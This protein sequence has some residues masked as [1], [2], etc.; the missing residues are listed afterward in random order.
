MNLTRT[1]ASN[2]GLLA[3]VTKKVLAVAAFWLLNIST[4]K[5]QP[6]PCPP[7]L[8]FETGTFFLWTIYEGTYNGWPNTN[9]G[10]VPVIPNPTR[11]QITSGAGLDPYGSFPEVAPG[12]GTYSLKLGND[13]VGAQTDRARYYIHVP[14]NANN[15]SFVYKYAVVFEDPGHSVAQQPRFMIRAYDSA[16]GIE[17]P[18]SDQLFIAGGNIPGF[19]TSPI[20]N[21]VRFKPWSSGS[22]NL[23]G[24][25]GKT[26]IVDFE[27]YDC[28]PTGH[29]GYGY[30][31]MISCGTYNAVVA[32]CNLTA[33]GITLAGPPG[34]MTYQWYTSNW[35]PVAGGS[36][37]IVPNVAAPNPASYFYLVLIPYSGPLC[38]DTLQ[39]NLVADITLQVTSDTLCYK[40]GTPVQITTNIG[41]G[42]PPLNIQWTG[43]D[44]S[45]YDCVN[46][47]STTTGNPFY[48]VTVTDSNGCFRKDTIEF[49]ESNFTM[50]AGDSF[51][52]CIGTPVQLN[53]WVSPGTGNYTYTW[54][55]NTGL[56]N[57]N[58][59]TPTFTPST[60]TLGDPVTYILTI[61]SGYCRK[62]DSITI[63]TLP[64][65]FTLLDTAVC[66]GAVF[67]IG[68]TG[69]P[70]FTYKWT[71]TIGLLDSTV[72]NPF[73][74][75]DTTR[76]Y[77]VTASYPTC[78]TIVKSVTV[79]VQP[80]PIVSLG[81]DTTKC[82]WDI[83][84]INVN[85]T[86]NWYTNYTYAWAAHP[87]LSSINSPNVLFTGQQSAGL[88]V[89]VTTPA[90]CS[91][92]DSLNITVYPGDFAKVTPLDTAVCPNS[93]VPLHIT[94][95]VA[96]DWTP[97]M[98]L[99]DSTIADPVSYPV[100][101][102]DYVTVVVDQYGC[103]DTVYSSIKVNSEALVFMTDT[104]EIYPDEQA[105]LDPRGN[106]LYYQWWPPV[107]LSA[108]AGITPTK[109]AN[110][111]AS[112]EVNTRYYVQ[113]TTEAG[114]SIIDSINVIVKNET[115]LDAPNAF[116]PGSA[117]NDI[118]KIVK[119]GSA[120]LKSFRVF[121][122][123]GAKVFE[124][125]NI[126][127]GWDGRLNGQPQPMGVYV[128]MIEAVTKSGK[129]FVK[130]GNVTLIR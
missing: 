54:T 58:A 30:V 105:Q 84:P 57:A 19:S 120:T 14:N 94:G 23:S 87:G 11:H 67:Q 92:Q 125:T 90:G 114:C 119:R 83:F 78:P 39:T 37:Q 6:I 99:N 126:D 47:I 101:D 10:P 33:G 46:P 3:S 21:A 75:I 40:G 104:I 49:I 100:T 48:T 123:W 56:N 38:A 12:G 107:G 9:W 2:I 85:V 34:Y 53:A 95:G 59:L 16:T 86:P 124:T 18:C 52:T 8:D 22:V 116:T 108:P 15:Y 76:V 65:D 81:P 36:S 26:I 60:A 17:V 32:A 64:N 72:V 35:T 113:A 70:A 89:L 24:Q 79:D 62:V 45:C 31:D 63:Q 130:Q 110:P 20:G 43:P 88:Y 109:I 50:D 41:G 129:T 4:V 74:A 25:A 121:N 13:Q 29:F 111:M 51:V 97:A 73:V 91:G 7:N 128:Y 27:T 69:H 71:P 82:Q 98:F 68:A 5:A 112:P 28:S 93:S 42:I 61:D 96:Y 1:R 66:K 80:V 117:P 118:L 44:L 127:E 102:V 103:K 77:T 122:R 106:A 55:P 115:I